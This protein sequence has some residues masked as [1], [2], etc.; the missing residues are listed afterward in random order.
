MRKI[1][2]VN[3]I[4][5]ETGIGKTEVVTV[6]E[7]FMEEIKDSLAK[8]ENVYLRGFGT[9]EIKHRAAKPAQ[10]ISA[11]KTIVVPAHD[12][13]F[14]KPSPEMKAGSAE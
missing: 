4:V 1:D 8:G 12:V 7:S 2:I 10:N 11:K 14:F 5:K 13:P 3:A 6:V 9:F